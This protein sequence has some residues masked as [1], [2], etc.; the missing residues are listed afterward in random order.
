MSE[1]LD[2]RGMRC[3]QPVLK[4]AIKSNTL[5][6]G[7]TIEV[8]ADCPTFA[9]DIRKWCTDTGK[10]LV[11]CIDQGSHRVATILL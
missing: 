5:S 2:C 7:T 4:V 6:A 8:K 9:D 11:S 1:V 10:S 3:P